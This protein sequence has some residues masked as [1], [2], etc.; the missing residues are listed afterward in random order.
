M[1]KH[2]D[3]LQE[4]EVKRPEQLFVSDITYI[5][6]DESVHYLSL[7]TDAALRKIMGHELSHEI[8][9]SDTV[10]ALE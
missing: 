6:S 2:P 1:K 7:V 9:A 5:E 8:K 3:L 4:M 10:K